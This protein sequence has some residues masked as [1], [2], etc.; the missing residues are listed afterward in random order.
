MKVLV[1]STPIFKLVPPGGTIGYS[2]LEC[3]AYQTATGLAKLGHEVSIVAPDGSECPGCTVIPCGP[4][5]QVN[6][7]GAYQ[8]YWQHLNDYQVAILHCWEKW[9][10]MLKA[11]GKLKIPLLGVFHAPVNSMY[12]VWPPT[13]PGLPPV[14]NACP[15]C[16][17]QDQADHFKAL[18]G[19]EARTCLNGIDLEFYK[20]LGIP[21]TDR[22]LFLARFSSIK[23]ADLA[24]DAC[25]KAGAGLDLVGDTSITNE[26]D[27]LTLC[28]K[29]AEQQSP[30]WDTSKGKQIRIIGGVS[31]G[32]CVHWYSQAHAFLHPNLRFRE[33]LGLAPIEAQ[34]VGLPVITFDHGAMRETVKHGETG[35]V[36]KS[37]DEFNKWVISFYSGEAGKYPWVPVDRNKCREWA[38]KFS[39]ERMVS[40]YNDLITEAVETGGW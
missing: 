19:R 24:I 30:N 25:L 29:K 2:G 15:V 5:R 33:P 21:R 11:E 18:H 31:R 6:E 38:S 35:W 10:Y 3:I 34:A 16:I 7:H 27:Y 39:I 14:E 20:P 4:E 40:R 1:T 36:A 22:F 37:V 32:E 23:G 28:Q 9:A 8:K 13:Y 17:S 12:G 26:P